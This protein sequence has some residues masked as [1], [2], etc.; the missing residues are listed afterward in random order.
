M[1]WEIK[2]FIYGYVLWIVFYQVDCYYNNGLNPV[3]VDLSVWHQRTPRVAVQSNEKLSCEK[4]NLYICEEPAETIP[5]YNSKNCNYRNNWYSEQV[6]RWVAGRGCL[7]YTPN[8]LYQ[9]GSNPINLNARCVYGNQF[10]PCLEIA[11]EDGTCGCFPFDPNIEEVATIIRNSL[12]PSAQGRWEKCYYAA[13]YCCSHFMNGNHNDNQCAATFDG[14]T[15]WPPTDSGTTAWSDCPEFAYSNSGPTCTHYSN[16]ECHGNGTWK[17]QTDY[18]TCSVTPRLLARYK[19]YVAMLGVSVVTCLPAVFIFFFYKR[20]R[21]TRVALHRN[22]LIAIIIRN[23]FVIISRSAIYIDELTG[24][25]NTVMSRNEV[26]CRVVSIFERAA[27]NAVF[28]CML[29][30]GIYLHRRIVAVFRRKIDIRYLYGIVAVVGT[31]PVVVWSVVMFLLNDHSCWV[32]YTVPHVQWSLDGPRVLVLLVNTLLFADVLRV[33]LTNIRN[34]ENA[35][36]LS[37]TKATLFLIPIFGT[38]FL[39]T[40]IRPKTD[41][42]TLEQIYYFVAYSIEGLQGFIVAMLY[43]YVNKEVRALIK[44]TY[45]KTEIAVTSKIKGNKYPR[46]SDVTSTDRRLT[47]ST[48]VISKEDYSHSMKPNLHVA[49]IISIQ[50]SERLAEILE[51]VYET[52]DGL[53]NDGYDYLE[54]SDADND[55]GFIPNRNSKVDDYYGFTHASSVS[56][57]CQDWLKNTTPNNSTQALTTEETKDLTSEANDNRNP[58]KASDDLDCDYA[59]MKAAKPPGADEFD[60]EIEYGNCEMLD[61]IMEYI[62]ATNK[63]VKLDPVLAADECREAVKKI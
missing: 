48:G 30:E 12:V 42:C 46:M 25:E 37:T 21:I 1:M 24:V 8:F 10:A 55:S 40:A 35:N 14:W 32:V 28:V 15:C 62:E 26:W 9:G 20:L 17:L 34:T 52:I 49:E 22:L 16:K 31:I 19:F 2:T 60:S 41:N 50:A 7:V 53:T 27:S 3:R 59:N 56:I 57:T 61:E 23:I 11:K 43:C 6:F 54:R 39:F 33:L 4:P 13:S 58:F 29:V 5:I 18:T 51:P 47:C 38:Q 45:K 36:Q 63:N 44:A